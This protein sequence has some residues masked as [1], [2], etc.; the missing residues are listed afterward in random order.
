MPVVFVHGVGLGPLPYIGFITEMAGQ[1][2]TIVLELPFVSQRLSAG[3]APP[4]HSTVRAIEGAMKRHGIATAT[5]VGHSLGSV[6]LSW[7]AKLR[8]NLVASFVFID[9]IVFL[10]HHHKVAHS[11]L[12]KKPLSVLE[13]VENYFVKSEQRI[14]SY[15]HREFFWYKNLLLADQLSGIPTAV[16]LSQEDSIVPVPAVADYLTRYSSASLSHSVLPG[17][18]HGEFLSNPAWSDHVLGV[19]RDAQLAGSRPVVVPSRWYKGRA[20]VKGVV[21]DAATD[22]RR[23]TRQ[24]AS[25]PRAA[26]G[27]LFSPRHNTLR[28]FSSW[29]V[30]M[31]GAINLPS[32]RSLPPLPPLPRR[33]ALSALAARQTAALTALLDS[34]ARTAPPYPP[35]LQQGLLSLPRFLEFNISTADREALRTDIDLLRTDL[36]AAAA[37]LAA[38]LSDKNVRRLQKAARA[39]TLEYRAV[40]AAQLAVRSRAVDLREAQGL[41]GDG[42]AGEYGEISGRFIQTNPADLWQEEALMQAQRA[43]AEAAAKLARQRSAA[44]RALG[45]LQA[46]L[47]AGDAAG[48][49]AGADADAEGSDAEAKAAGS[50]RSG[51]GIRRR[52]W[53]RAKP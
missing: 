34:D 42:A 22:F 14:V 29:E 52:W 28:P 4:P 38:A 8:P 39:A 24:L 7:V 13:V 11:F 48:D 44:R 43:L 53:R 45:V 50:R 3:R 5:F 6:Y 21:A 49:A 20:R 30:R 15:F 31:R 16:V 40:R 33:A 47:A 41:G 35:E 10:L 18:S 12:Y 23:A 27:A 37:P 2:P 26:A 32:L 9:P 51:V 36:A 17:A 19:V 1:S 46:Q 25:Y